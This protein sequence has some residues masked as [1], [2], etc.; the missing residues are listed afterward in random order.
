VGLKTRVTPPPQRSAF[1]FGLAAKMG[2]MPLAAWG[3]SEA[4]HAPREVLHVNVLESAMPSMITAAA[5]ASSA[6]IMPE[7][8][9]A[10]VGWGI[11]LSLLTLRAWTALLG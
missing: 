8:A 4:V 7:L 2:L 6:G 9:A 10:L 1:V 11:L 5:L 3:L